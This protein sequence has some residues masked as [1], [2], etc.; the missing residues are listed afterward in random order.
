[1]S[2]VEWLDRAIDVL[3]RAGLQVVLEYP[4]ATPPVWLSRAHPDIL[5]VDADELQRDHGTRRHYCPNSTTYRVQSPNC[6]CHGRTLRTHP[7]VIGW[8][9]D[10]EFMAAAR[11]PVVTVPI[12]LRHSQHGWLRGT[13]SIETLN[14][15]WGAVFWSQSY[16]GFDEIRPPHAGVNYK[17]ES[18]ARFLSFSAES[19]VAYQQEQIDILRDLAPNHFITQLHGFCIAISISMHWPKPSILRLGMRTRPVFRSAGAISCTR[20]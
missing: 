18:G 3:G 12:A 6:A 5:R 16:A 8:Q 13:K 1:M 17:S 11:R 19:Y 4:T 7:H 2:T 15:A 9:I 20:C 14:E 10:N